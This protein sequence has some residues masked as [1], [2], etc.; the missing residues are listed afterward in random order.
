MIRSLDELDLATRT[1]AREFLDS[2]TLAIRAELRAPV[3]EDLIAHLCERLEASATP[4]DLERVVA[5]LGAVGDAEPESAATPFW[6]RIGAG[7]RVRGMADRIAGTLWNPVDERLLVPR[8]V[9]WGW[10]L[11]FGSVAV[12]L[13]WIEP[14]AEA[15]PFTATPAA[16][17]RVAAVVPG[18]LA[19]ATVVH[20]LWR[21]PGLPQL[22]PSH[23]DLAGRPDRWVSKRRAV[24]T[25]LLV[26]GGA[27]AIAAWA[28]GSRRPGPSKAGA[29]AGATLVG[30]AAATT[31]LLRVAGSR[32]GLWV[33][34]VMLA[35]T[36][37]G[38]GGVL[39]GLAR[40]GRTAEI[41]QDRESR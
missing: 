22:L 10:D 2:A 5:E 19:A 24:T 27:A 41:A 38:V 9:G 17:F 36:T 26:T 34:P 39:V 23:W 18:A 7:L 13:G 31:A 33:G 30:S 16:A 11:N 28:A 29:I 4:A 40:A 20:Y 37:A 35:S 21:G 1:A 32:G 25:D 14:D 8:A 6:R 15:V 12:R 3:R